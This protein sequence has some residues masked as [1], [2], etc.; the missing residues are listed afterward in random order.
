MKQKKR[1]LI[2]VMLFASVVT[3]AYDFE[4]GGL[5]Y[6][7]ISGTVSAEVTSGDNS[8]TGAVSIP[9]SVSYG[10]K[11]Y[12]VKKV[13]FKAFHGCND[14]NSVVFPSSIEEIEQEAFT[15]CHNLSIITFEGGKCVYSSKCF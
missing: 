10:G 13:G 2:F 9:A 12:S 5:Y 1:L 7:I 3:K 11:T 15:N 14:L 4:S 8:Y 6:N